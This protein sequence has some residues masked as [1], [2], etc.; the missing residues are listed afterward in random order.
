MTSQGEP[1]SKGFFVIIRWYG[2]HQPTKTEPYEA[3]ADDL[4]AQRALNHSS[5]LA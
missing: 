4:R 5:S 1:K 2:H 3:Q